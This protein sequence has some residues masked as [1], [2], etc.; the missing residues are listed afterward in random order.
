[1]GT[2]GTYSI[3]NKTDLNNDLY[4]FY[5]HW[6][7]YPEGATAKFN[8]MLRLNE[9]EDT[10][11]GLVESFLRGNPRASFTDNIDQHGDT[12]YH[13]H[14]TSKLIIKAYKITRDWERDTSELGLIFEGKLENFINKYSEKK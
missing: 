14:L 1:M 10:R 11:G 2:R 13:Y 7:S 8:D 5:C 9:C 12:E 4:H 6:D 3:E